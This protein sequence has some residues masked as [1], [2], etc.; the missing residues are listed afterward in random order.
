MRKVIR[1]GPNSIKNGPKIKQIFP[2]D[3]ERFFNTMETPVSNSDRN[4][5]ARYFRF[6]DGGFKKFG[7]SGVVPSCVLSTIRYENAQHHQL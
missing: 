3:V 6:D 7:L 2:A 1:V 5:G 4:F